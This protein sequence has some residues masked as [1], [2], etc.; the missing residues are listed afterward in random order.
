MTKRAKKRNFTDTEIEVLV[1]GVKTNQDILFG[2]LNAG[3]TNKQKNAAWD[4][5]ADAVNSVGSERRLSI[6]E[7]KKKWFDIK[8]NAKKRVTAHRRETSL[9]GGGQAA[10]QLTPMDTRIASIIGDTAL[11]GIIPGGDTDTLSTEPAV[12]ST[13][14]TAGQ[15]KS[16]G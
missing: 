8:L 6:P 4:R 5:V 14:Q 12:P 13:S 15:I 11:C 16:L 9:T 7:I 10:T 3:I 1:G 2:T